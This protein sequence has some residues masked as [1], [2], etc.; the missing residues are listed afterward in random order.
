MTTLRDPR[1]VFY[2]LVFLAAILFTVATAITVGAVVSTMEG[3][4]S[5][6][7]NTVAATSLDD[8]SQTDLEQELATAQHQLEMNTHALNRLSTDA[9]WEIPEQRE[10]LMR[11]MQETEAIVYQ[12]RQRVEELERM[13]GA[14]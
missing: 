2:P 6:I 8:V 10:H 3:D 14:R 13:L 1:H 9:R 11:A 12:R 5:M 7:T 4:P